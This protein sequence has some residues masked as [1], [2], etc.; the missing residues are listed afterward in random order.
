MKLITNYL[1]RA[2]YAFIIGVFFCAVNSTGNA[3]ETKDL[4]WY[5]PDFPPANFVN[6]L[7]QGLGY[8]DQTQKFL[9]Q[10]MP[11]YKHHKVIASY[12]RTLYDLKHKNGCAVGFY[13]DVEREKYLIFSLPNLLTFPNGLVIKEKDLPKF[14]QYLDKNNFISIYQLIKDQK[15]HL[16][17]ANDRRYAGAIDLAIK[18]SHNHNIYFREGENVFSSLLHMLDSERIDYM[19]GFPEELEYHRSLGILQNKMKFIPIKEML[20]Y[21]LSYIVCSKNSWGKSVI[22][23]INKIIK[24]QRT[25]DQYLRF[26]EFWLDFDS[27]KRHH[28]LSKEL[29]SLD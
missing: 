22:Y 7:M 26:Y 5:F 13:K 25:S 18:Q 17:V 12:K 24:K 2:L 11:N 6:G 21:E 20:K 14:S 28:Q 9:M 10:N 8:N 23:D 3:A 19:F 29:F 16:G 1:K 15:L 4:F 27:K